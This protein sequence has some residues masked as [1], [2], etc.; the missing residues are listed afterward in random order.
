M[1]YRILL[2][3]LAATAVWAQM[4]QAAEAARAAVQKSAAANSAAAA[5]AAPAAPAGPDFLAMNPEAVVA[6]VDG[7]EVTAGE[8]Q[9]FARTLPPQMQQQ[10][11][12]NPAQVLQT[13]GMLH[14]FAGQAEKSKL[15]E[16]S[17]WKEMLE[18]TR[19]QVL[20]QAWMNQHIAE[21]TVPPA[22]VQKFYDAN[23]DRFVEA[24]VKSIY[25]PFQGPGGAQPQA[26]DAKKPLSEAEAKAK[27]DDV[28]KKARVAAADF[29]A[30]AK[31]YSGDPISAAKGG[32]FGTI[33]KASQVPAAIKDAIFKT[34]AGEVTEPVRQPNGFYI[35]RVDEI[36]TQ[37]FEK[38]RDTIAEELKNGRVMEWINSVQNSIEIKMAGQPSSAPSGAQ[39]AAPPK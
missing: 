32:D 1:K 29:G 10:A 22:E 16:A 38:V 13:L 28:V 34:K 5:P 12:A 36:G 8:L 35:F 4:D 11:L 7:R 3:F 9:S 31:E 15:I 20:A 19:T 25:V 33:S 37:P 27:A 2:P 39:P 23:K 24:K 30:L 18:N 26:G 6:T 17:P 21:M 14:R